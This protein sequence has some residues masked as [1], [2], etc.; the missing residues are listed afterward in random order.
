MS[1]ADQIL[2]RDLG[3]SVAVCLDDGS[4]VIVRN[5]EFD[6]TS[7]RIEDCRY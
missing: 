5:L 4:V 7:S 6:L 3:G 2:V 1:E